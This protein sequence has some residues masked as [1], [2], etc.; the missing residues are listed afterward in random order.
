MSER[1][2]VQFSYNIRQKHNDQPVRNKYLCDIE[3]T[4]FQKKYYV[5]IYSDED[6]EV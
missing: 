5:G 3:P 1:S 4:L 6:E 2:F